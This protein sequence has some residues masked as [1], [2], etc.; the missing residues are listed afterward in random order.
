MNMRTGAGSLEEHGAGSSFIKLNVSAP[1]QTNLMKKL[2]QNLLKLQELEFAARID[3]DGEA[4]IAKLRRQ[5][6]LPILKHYDRLTDQGKKGVALVSHQSCTGCH[7]RVPIGAIV[8]LMRGDDIQMC[9]TC[10]RYLYLPAEEQTE[11]R[12]ASAETKAAEAKSRAKRK[13]LVRAV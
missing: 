5:I 3:S 8:T 10:G 12:E 2:I 4:A 13:P 1:N 11:F 9:E 7:M 6:P